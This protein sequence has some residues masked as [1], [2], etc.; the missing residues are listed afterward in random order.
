MQAAGPRGRWLCL[1]GPTAQQTLAQ[2]R[3]RAAAQCCQCHE[4]QPTERCPAVTRRNP[5]CEPEARLQTLCWAAAQWAAAPVRGGAGR[6]AATRDPTP[7]IQTLSQAAARWAVAAARQAAALRAQWGPKLCLSCRAQS[8]TRCRLVRVRDHMYVPPTERGRG[9]K[10]CGVSGGAPH[11]TLRAPL[12]CWRAAA[13]RLRRSK[14]ARGAE[15]GGRAPTGP[16]AWR[17]CS[18]AP[19]SLCSVR[20]TRA[21]AAA[22][23]RRQ[24]V[25]GAGGSH[26]ATCARCC[27]RQTARAR[28]PANPLGGCAWTASRGHNVA[29]RH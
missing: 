19:H 25:C 15:I 27:P 16:R 10:R 17:G 29:R 28:C 6:C 5:T 8:Q 20:Q 2:I 9:A 4:S 7:C 3:P 12:L 13:R 21:H 26:A 14:R 23:R 24:P 1:H 22:P 18:C 11:T